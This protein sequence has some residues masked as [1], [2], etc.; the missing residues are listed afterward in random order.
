MLTSLYRPR[1]P[2]NAIAATTTG[3]LAFRRLQRPRARSEVTRRPVCTAR[4]RRRRAARTKVSAHFCFVVPT[5]TACTV[6]ILRPGNDH[7]QC[8]YDATLFEAVLPP[9]SVAER[10]F[11]NTRRLQALMAHLTILEGA[12][13]RLT[14]LE[15]IVASLID[16]SAEREAFEVERADTPDTLRGFPLL[17]TLS[18]EGLADVANKIQATASLGGIF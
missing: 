10:V 4:R 17:P 1:R 5:P 15:S 3:C 7:P 13:D 2:T 9:G 14:P 18:V 12:T 6:R 11:N 8:D 16:R